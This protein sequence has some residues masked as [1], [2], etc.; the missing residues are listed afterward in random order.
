MAQ[1]KSPFQWLII[2]LIRGYQLFI[3]PLLGQRCRFH[4]SCSHY[5]I[6]A[7]QVHGVLKGSWLSIKRIIKCHPLNPGGNDPVPPKNNRCN[8]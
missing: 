7:V 6:E 2:K 1:V 4:P 3:S 5:A 8:K